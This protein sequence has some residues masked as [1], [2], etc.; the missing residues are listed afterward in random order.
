M[1]DGQSEACS[2]QD[3]HERFIDECRAKVTYGVPGLSISEQRR[4]LELFT[5][6]L[7]ETF[8]RST[9]EEQRDDEG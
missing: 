5:G 9:W 6:P 1:T 2:A 3:E 7:P 4:L 8:A